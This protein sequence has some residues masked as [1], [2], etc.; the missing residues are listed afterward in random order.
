M[1]EH[2]VDLGTGALTDAYGSNAE[3]ATATAESRAEV[4]STHVKIDAFLALAE[5]G[6]IDPATI[7]DR[8]FDEH[9]ALISRSDI[10]PDDLGSYGSDAI[11]SMGSIATDHDISEAYKDAFLQYYGEG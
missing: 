5:A 6:V 4:G 7:D 2:G 3:A 11:G 9:G 1:W 8:W 10:A